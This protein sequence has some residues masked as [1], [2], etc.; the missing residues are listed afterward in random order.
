MG[1]ALKQGYI[2]ASFLEMIKE[3]IR[4]KVDLQ[5]LLHTYMSES[6]FDKESSFSYPN[7]RFIHQGLYLPGYKHERSRLKLMI[8]LDRSM[9]ISQSTF[10]KFLGIIDGILRMG[11][12]FEVSVIPF[13]ERVDSKKIVQYDSQQNPVELSFEKGN[14]GTLIESLFEYIK[15]QG[16]MDNT[17]MVLSD[18][19]FVIEKAPEIKTLFLISQKKNMKR[20]ER[21]GDV[22]YFDL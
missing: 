8:G 9:S 4:P 6:F 16:E 20:L 12:D 22:F 14:G 5:T 21:F 7:R 15:T 3:V 2:P 19:L 11:A 10:S 13:D 1:A 18:G 17:L